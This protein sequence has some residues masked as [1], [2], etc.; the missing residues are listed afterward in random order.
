MTTQM[1]HASVRTVEFVTALA[2]PAEVH[3]EAQRVAQRFD[4]A[5]QV[6]LA[7]HPAVVAYF[8]QAMEDRAEIH[9]GLRFEVANPD[10][11]EDWAE[12]IIAESFQRFKQSGDLG[13]AANLRR[14]DSSL[15]VV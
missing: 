14:E 9:V 15:V 5:V 2:V 11:V 3:D 6:A 1:T 8:V 10:R 13:P 4:E 7:S 12:D